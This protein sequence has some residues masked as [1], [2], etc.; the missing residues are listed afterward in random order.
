MKRHIS[1][2]C[3]QLFGR[4]ADKA[5]P[6]IV[7][8]MI[9]ALYVKLMGV[10][11]SRFKKACDYPTL[12]ALF[13]RELESLPPMPRAKSKVIAPVDGLVTECGTVEAGRLYQIKGMAYDLATLLREASVETLKQMEGG[14]YA[15]YYLAPYDYHRYHAPTDLEVT[16]VRYIPGKLYPVNL[17]YLRKKPKLFLENERVVLKARDVKG[18]LHFIVLVGALNV[19]RLRLDFLPTLQE[20]AKARKERVYD[21]ATKPVVLQRG[22]QMGYFEMGST[23]VHIAQKG[24]IRLELEINRKVR[25]GNVV[26]KLR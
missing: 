17:R 26:G 5:F 11:L 25:F 22:E 24:A 7:Q 20:D 8:H 23:V 14:T 3:S 21:F 6:S 1:L 18:R 12:N 13:T 16:E 4:F 15:N 10:D 19:G 9:N 2:V